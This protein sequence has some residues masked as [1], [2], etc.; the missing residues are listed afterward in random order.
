MS[1]EADARIIIDKFLRESGWIMPGEELTTNVITEIKN[2]AGDADYILLDSKGFHLC[3]VE[4]KRSS[5]SPL[6]GKEQARDYAK[7]LKCRFI[8]L[9]NSIE[10]YLWDLEQGNPYLVEKLP[11]QEQLE[12]KNIT[13]TIDDE[14]I[15]NDYIALTQ[16]PNYM[17]NPDF[18]DESKRSDFSSQKEA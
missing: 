2:D 10:H 18:I 8:L 1:T 15:E 7:S 9:S 4:A 6:V 14:E 11:S 17:K 13:S 5:L 12:T 3:T 16:D